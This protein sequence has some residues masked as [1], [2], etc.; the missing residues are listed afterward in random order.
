[1]PI[2]GMSAGREAAWALADDLRGQITELHSRLRKAETRLEHLAI[3]LETITGFAEPAPGRPAGPARAPDYP[4][5]LAVFNAATG[6]LRARDVC[7]ALGHELLPK[8]IETHPRQAD[9]PGRAP[10]PHRGR[11]R[12]LHQEAVADEHGDHR[13]FPSLI[14]KATSSREPPSERRRRAHLRSSETRVAPSLQVK[15]PR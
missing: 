3:I 5:I 13:P 6:P 12:Q 15:A 10:R 2:H 4:Q 7:E 11:D 1:M 8:N 14:P 9:T